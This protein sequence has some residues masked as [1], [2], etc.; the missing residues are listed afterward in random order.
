MEK[1]MNFLSKVGSEQNYLLS[2]KKKKL[3]MNSSY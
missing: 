2:F 3:K 1:K